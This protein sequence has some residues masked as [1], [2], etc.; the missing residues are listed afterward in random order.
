MTSLF[1]VDLASIDN[2]SAERQTTSKQRVDGLK[3]HYNQSRIHQSMLQELDCD[4]Q[5]VT[6]ADTAAAV[7][8]SRRTT[9]SDR[10]DASSSSSCGYF[11]QTWI[12]LS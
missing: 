5:Q 10:G 3:R 11:R 6:S 2:R 12:L 7:V 9:A 1:P 8:Q 4:Q